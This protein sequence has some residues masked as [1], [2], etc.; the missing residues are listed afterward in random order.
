MRAAPPLPVTG[1]DARPRVAAQSSCRACRA[2]R[3]P[4]SLQRAGPPGRRAARSESDS[5]GGWPGQAAVEP[6]LR[7]LWPAGLT[8]IG[9][10]E[11]AGVAYQSESPDRQRVGPPARGTKAQRSETAAVGPAST[12]P[13]GA[14]RDARRLR[15]R[16]GACGGRTRGPRTA[17]PSGRGRAA[18]LRRPSRAGCG[19]TCG[20]GG[21]G[22]RAARQACLGYQRERERERERERDNRIVK[23]SNGQTAEW[24][25]LQIV[26]KD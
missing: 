25:N 18:R 14:A 1:D 22:A 5:D 6:N 16:C 4:H 7:N 15:H 24:S 19:G 20:G 26:K 21:G 12:G 23:K 9:L 13:H 11:P 3:N 17:S 8:R 10:Q 2:V